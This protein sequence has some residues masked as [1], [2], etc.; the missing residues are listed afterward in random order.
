M[1]LSEAA[2]DRA[3][4]QTALWARSLVINLGALVLCRYLLT[5]FEIHGV[6]GYILAAVGLEV[7]TIAWLL[8]IRVWHTT[9]FA[10]D[11]L[12]LGE[13]LVARLVFVAMLVALTVVIPLVLAT[14][15]PGL[16]FAVWISPLKIAHVSTFVLACLVI[17]GLTIVLR[18]SRPLRFIRAFV[19]GPGSKGGP[20]DE[21]LDPTT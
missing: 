14:S 5:G 10:G 3:V 20:V 15:A 7:P 21:T 13:F 8:L 16:V 18:Q 4:Q 11:D 2:A 12:P 19:V 1:E 9:A 17:S 6:W